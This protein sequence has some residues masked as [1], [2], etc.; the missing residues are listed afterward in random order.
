MVGT[1]NGF[2]GFAEALLFRYVYRA[3]E[4]TFG[5]EFEEEKPTKDTVVFRSDS[6]LLTHDISLKRY[7][8]GVNHRSDIAF[9]HFD[10]SPPGKLIAAFEL[11]T[12]IPGPAQ[13]GDLL[14]RLEEVL[15]KTDALVFPILFYAQNRS[16]LDEFCANYPE[17]CYVISN[18]DYGNKIRLR[19][20]G[21]KVCV[22]YEKL[23]K[24]VPFV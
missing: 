8:V 21:Q 7:Q 1:S 15:T 2:S 23:T 20:V 17:R 5:C 24:G 6:M 12:A 4:K 19:E 13:L 9:L 16:R 14:D 10:G 18:A 22:H 11:K 3:I